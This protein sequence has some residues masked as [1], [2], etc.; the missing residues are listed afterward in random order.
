MGSLVYE[1]TISWRI[2]RNCLRTDSYESKYYIYCH[3]LC[4]T[5]RWNHDSLRSVLLK[6]RLKTLHREDAAIVVV[7]C[8]SHC[9][10]DPRLNSLNYNLPKVLSRLST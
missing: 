6:F 10:I 7:N 5:A 2:P 4:S 3:A 9:F 8:G 1:L